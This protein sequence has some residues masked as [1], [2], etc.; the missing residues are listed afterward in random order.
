MRK[1]SK[2]FYLPLTIIFIISAISL[3]VAWLGGEENI[4][5]NFFSGVAFYT[6]L[7]GL[8]LV[9]IH[10]VIL[11][12]S[13]IQK[14]S[15]YIYLLLQNSFIVTILS[16]LLAWVGKEGSLLENVFGSIGVY[17]VI[18]CIYLFFIH[19]ISLILVFIFKNNSKT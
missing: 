17:G 8:F 15:K 5:G 16:L 7:I 10:I 1:S 14:N 18:I 3:V 13:F 9:F 19:V 6:A 4:F 11:I 2:Y 12:L